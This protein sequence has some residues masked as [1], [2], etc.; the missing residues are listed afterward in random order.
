MAP[1][2]DDAAM[3]PIRPWP[4]TAFQ[5]TDHDATVTLIIFAERDVLGST[6]L[7]LR[8]TVPADAPIEALEMRIHR[9]VEDP[10]WIDHW[11]TG[12]LRTV[13]ADQL[14]DVHRLDTAT[15]CY[16]VT[17]TIPDPPDLT[18]L[19]LA[20]AIA[21]RLASKG[22]FAVLDAHAAAWLPGPVVAALPADRS[23]TVRDEIALIAENTPT[24]GF[25]H[26][27]HTRGMLKFG[28][29]DLI[30][31][32]PADRIEQTGRI[33]NHLASLQADGHVLAVGQRLRADGR[34]VTVAPY[35][36]DG[37]VPEVNLNNDGLLLR[38]S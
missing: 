32:V 34:V 4:R 1:G 23:C 5:R 37:I 12:A 3:S 8:G 10:G 35:A 18:H 27:V 14:D 7:E 19:Q 36:P 16:S 6:D 25:G 33:L 21:S 20:W 2:C 15:C 38:D 31:G 17:L 29:P 24:P 22:A 9:D 28:R 13:A 11:R 30:A 26:A